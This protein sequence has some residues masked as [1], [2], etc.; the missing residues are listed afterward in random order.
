MSDTRKIEEQTKEELL[1]DCELSLEDL[2]KVTGGKGDIIEYVALRTV[3][4]PLCGRIYLAAI[5][6]Y[7]THE[8]TD[9]TCESKYCSFYCAGPVH[10]NNLQSWRDSF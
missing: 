9:I 4:C 8:Y 6:D 10:K 1:K 2:G 5:Y 3:T 7:E